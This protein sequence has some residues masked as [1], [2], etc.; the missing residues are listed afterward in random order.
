MWCTDYLQERS[1]GLPFAPTPFELPSGY[2]IIILAVLFIAIAIQFECLCL[3]LVGQFLQPL[4]SDADVLA[5]FMEIST[6]YRTWFYN[7]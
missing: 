7:R 5:S 2:P 1:I 3:V 6:N 4:V